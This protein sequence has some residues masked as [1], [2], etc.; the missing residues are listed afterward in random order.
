MSLSLENTHRLNN[1]RIAYPHLYH[2]AK[3]Q[4]KETKYMASLLIEPVAN[5]EAMETIKSLIQDFI[6]TENRGNPLSPDRICF[7]DGNTKGNIAFKNQWVLRASN[8]KPIREWRPD[9][10]RIENPSESMIYSGCYVN[11]RINLWWQGDLGYG[12]RINCNFIAAQFCRHGEPI[13]G[14][15]MPDEVVADGFDKLAMPD[16]TDKEEIPF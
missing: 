9:K 11:A 15:Y 10:T 8:T 5:S 6:A 4:G 16:N 13:D 7:F 2:K 1:I 14:S 12:K 3:Y